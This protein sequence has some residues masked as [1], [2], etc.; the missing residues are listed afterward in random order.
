MSTVEPMRVGVVGCGMVAQMYVGGSKAFDT[1]KPVACADLDVAATE[2][3]AAKHGLRPETVDDLVAD[4]EIDLV[5]NLT[6]AAAHAAVTRAALEADKHVYTE[7][8]LA[9]TVDEG[10]ELVTEAERRGLRLGCAPD[11]FL[12][13]AYLA[14]KR[15][16]D[17]GAIGVPIG[18]SA[19][20]LLG[21]PD[22]WHPN[23]A[24]FYGPGGG[25]LLDLAPYYL[26]AAVALF[27][28]IEAVAGFATTPTP[29]R[30]LGA[31]PLAGRTIESEVPTHAAALLRMRQGALVML[32]VS[33]EAR[34]QYV[35]GMEVFGTEASL[36]LPNAN[37]FGGDILLLRGET[38]PE[39]VPYESLG[40]RETRGRGLDDLVESLRAGRPHRASG[41][42]ALHVLEAA[43]AVSRSETERRTIAL[44]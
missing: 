23:A 11:T 20:L 17:D 18:A 44:D 7:K 21:G 2:A 37:E 8:P 27:G 34:D 1:W 41:E 4:P 42:L 5:L 14:A 38:E 29:V 31:G 19:R 6:P 3:F 22:A 32:T 9:T 13:S 15:L 10:R 16:I 30:T 40:A 12:S 35:S 26:A 33:F 28:P 24:A 25:P 43:A 39:P 36:V